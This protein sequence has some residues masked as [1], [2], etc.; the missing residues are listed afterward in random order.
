MKIPVYRRAD[1]PHIF[2][3]QILNSLIRWFAVFGLIALVPSVVAAY[4]QG[5]WWVIVVDAGVY[6]LLLVL[7]FTSWFSHQTRSWFV[8]AGTALV[9]T[10]VL[11]YTGDEGAGFMWLMAAVVF[12]AS[13]RSSRVAYRLVTALAILTVAYAV[14][15]ATGLVASNLSG[16]IV[17]VIG[18]NV[19]VVV[20]A[21]THVVTQLVSRLRT[22]T[23]HQSKLLG[24]LSDELQENMEIQRSLR[25]TLDDKRAG[26]HE[27]DHRVRNNIQVVLSL[28]NLAECDG[29]PEALQALRLRIEALATVQQLIE[30]TGNAA[31]VEVPVLVLRTAQKVRAAFPQHRV[32]FSWCEGQE[33][34]EAFLGADRAVHL[35]IA[36]TELFSQSITQA[37]PGHE[38]S[39]E[40]S[41]AANDDHLRIT[42]GANSGGIPDTGNDLLLAALDQCGGRIELHQT[43]SRHTLWSIRLWN[44]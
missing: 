33:P 44:T 26:L 5:L 6:A 40:A 18:A 22:L 8:I 13:F 17:T 23:E 7:V 19:L 10:V 42:V 12:S 15:V 21:T 2:E 24:Q 4:V 27:L 34:P 3:T 16:P 35:A 1:I 43:G 38:L 29:S 36:C 11:L 32:H 20:T 41:I 30:P 37:E 14:A 28:M 31:D 9:G 25:Q 39:F